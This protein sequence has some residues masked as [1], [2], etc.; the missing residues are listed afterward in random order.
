M[1]EL[2]VDGYNVLF[3]VPRYRRLLES[4]PSTARDRLVQDLASFSAGHWRATVVFDGR[5]G[6]GS[7]GSEAAPGVSVIFAEAHTEADAIVE[8]LARAARERGDHAV[9]VTRDSSTGWAVLG[10]TVTR[11][12]PSELEDGLAEDARERDERGG[13]PRSGTTIEDR[14][15]HGTRSRLLRLRDSAD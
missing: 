14:I 4:D 13:R 9:V 6:S 2:I 7:A 5:S 8:S 10:G 12:A 11:M 15:G 3:S 1:R